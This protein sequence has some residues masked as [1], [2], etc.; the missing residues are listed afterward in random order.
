[1]LELSPISLSAHTLALEVTLVVAAPL[2]SLTLLSAAM[3]RIKRMF[4]AHFNLRTFHFL[5]NKI[6]KI[7][8]FDKHSSSSHSVS[9]EAFNFYFW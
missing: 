4:C 1:M 8:L 7:K 9:G 5:G 3:V 2:L 6:E